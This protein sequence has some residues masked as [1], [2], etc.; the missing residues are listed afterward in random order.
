MKQQKSTSWECLL[1]ETIWIFLFFSFVV[2][3]CG[4]LPFSPFS[5][6]PHFCLPFFSF[7]FYPFCF[8][9]SYLF[10]F[11]C[12]CFPF[13]VFIISS[14]C[15]F[16]LYVSFFRIFHCC[17]LPSCI[18]IFC[19]CIN[20]QLTHLSI[21]LVLLFCFFPFFLLVYSPTS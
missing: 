15:S 17:F 12:M 4:N 18:V 21:K 14:I 8:L 10:C 7:P 13:F 19:L 16:F 3:F 20:L 6:L 2:G 1:R 5:A 9:P 11:L